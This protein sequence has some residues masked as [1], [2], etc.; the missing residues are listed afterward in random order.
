MRPPTAV[1]ILIAVGHPGTLRGQAVADS[2]QVALHDH[3]KRPATS[4]AQTRPKCSW[5]PGEGYI[6]VRTSPHCRGYRS[7]V[8]ARWRFHWVGNRDELMT[9]SCA[10]VPNR[11][12]R[13]SVTPRWEAS[14]WRSFCSTEGSRCC[15]RVL[16]R[17]LRQTPTVAGIR[18]QFDAGTPPRPQPNGYTC[19]HPIVALGGDRSGRLLGR[20]HDLGTEPPK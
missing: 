1:L 6:R 3:T 19:F 14:W 4:F 13:Q 7:D 11:R 20:Y 2:T 8:H 5:T 18:A 17:V 12:P 9:T 10:T 16:A 15:C